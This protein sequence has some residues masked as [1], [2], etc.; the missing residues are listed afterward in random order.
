MSLTWRYEDWTSCLDAPLPFSV[1]Q[2]LWSRG[3]R[4]GGDAESESQLHAA[5]RTPFVSVVG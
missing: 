2:F 5:K 4:G 3:R 1:E